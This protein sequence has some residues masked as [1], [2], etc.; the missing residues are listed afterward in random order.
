MESWFD[1][2]DRLHTDM[3]YPPTHLSSNPAVHGWELNL[4]PVDH[5]SDALTT[6]PPNHL[7]ELVQMVYAVL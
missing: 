2:G 3:V 4:W 1:L 5:K 6:T 7:N